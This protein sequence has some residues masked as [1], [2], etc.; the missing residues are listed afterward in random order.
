MFDNAAKVNDIIILYCIIH[1]GSFFGD[2]RMFCIG[3]KFGGYKLM[4]YFGGS[5]EHEYSKAFLSTSMIP[6][7]YPYPIG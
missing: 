3:K 2:L 1:D 5:S 7:P 4:S 6:L